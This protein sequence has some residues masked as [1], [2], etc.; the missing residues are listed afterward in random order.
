MKAMISLNLFAHSFPRIFS[1]SKP[2]F[3]I[4]QN[5]NDI[6][7]FK[8]YFYINFQNKMTSCNIVRTYMK[9]YNDDSLNEIKYLN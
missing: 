9:N 2:C 3:T 8:I 5:L 6:Y 1:Y 7:I 4:Y